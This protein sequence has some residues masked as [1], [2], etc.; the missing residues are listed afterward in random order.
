[1]SVFVCTTTDVDEAVPIEDPAPTRVSTVREHVVGLWD[2]LEQ[3]KSL[4]LWRHALW[5]ASH[6][7]SLQDFRAILM[8][9]VEVPSR[10]KRTLMN[11]PE[12]VARWVPIIRAL[13][14]AHD[15]APIDA[16]EFEMDDHLT[17]LLSAPV[18]QIREFYTQLVAALKADPTIPF[19]VWAW[20]ESWGDV[21]LKTAPDGD[22]LALKDALATQIAEMVERQV[23]PDLRA[24][25]VGALK[26]R[27]PETLEQIR[28]AVAKGGKARMVGRSS[29]LFL[30]VRTGDDEACL[31]RVML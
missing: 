31:A 30:E 9:A 25:L 7:R 14:T 27:S 16:C 10:R 1:M 28:D 11:V 5:P 4:F 12:L 18:K 20:F 15:K 13:A 8:Y 6:V 17:P 22:V 21:I 29:C 3:A 2:V 23:Q 24:A 26:W 19:F